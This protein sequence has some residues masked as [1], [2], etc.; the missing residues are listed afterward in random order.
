MYVRNA[1]SFLVKRN[2]VQLTHEKGNVMNKNTFKFSGLA[3]ERAIDLNVGAD[4]K[5][6]MGLKTPKGATKPSKGVNTTP[7]TKN[8]RRV[9]KSI[10][11]QTAG[12]YYRADLTSAALARW[13][14]LHRLTK[15]Q[16]GLKKKAKSKTGRKPKA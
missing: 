16:Q 8:F 13:S 5:V 4:G 10:T 12:K 7:M 9:A 2:G 11:T 1:S 3:N 15:V 14:A 6:S